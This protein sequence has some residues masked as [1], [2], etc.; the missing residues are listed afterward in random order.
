VYVRY[1]TG[2]HI[3]HN[4]QDLAR[5]LGD[6]VTVWPLDIEHIVLIGHSMK[7]W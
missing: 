3:S 6:L 2:R 7:G 1:N 5:L 4:D